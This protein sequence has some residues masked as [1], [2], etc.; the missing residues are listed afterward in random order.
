M[1][2]PRYP[3]VAEVRASLRR[4]RVAFGD[5]ETAM[6]A[7]IA[8]DLFDKPIAERHVVLRG[9][10]AALGSLN[11]ALL[12]YLI[13]LGLDEYEEIDPILEEG[14]SDHGERTA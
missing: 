9:T 13:L 5:L 3:S 10:V 6:K 11:D 14:G 12:L 1:S 4:I 2:A 7:Q 8:Q